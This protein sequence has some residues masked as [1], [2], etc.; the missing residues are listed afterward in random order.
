MLNLLCFDQ[1][2][3]GEFSVEGVEWTFWTG[4]LLG[5]EGIVKG[6]DR[7]EALD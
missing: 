5:S 1:E 4:K 2:R 6:S 3:K 7:R